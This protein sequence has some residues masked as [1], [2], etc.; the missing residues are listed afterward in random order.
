MA[1]DDLETGIGVEHARQHKPDALRRGLDIEAPAGAQQAG[2]LLRVILVIG[3]DDGGLRDRRV[4]VDR[5]IERRGPLIDRPEALVIMEDAVGQTVDHR[6]FEAEL[7]HRAVELVGR[8]MRIGGRQGRKGG[9]AV[10]M[11]AHRLMQ[12]VV[13]AAR[14]RHAGRGVDALQTGDR[15]RQHLK[16]DAAFVHFCEPQC[17]EIVEPFLETT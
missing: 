4:D 9:E 2:M 15:M 5:H 6:A 16:I 17:A 8:G 14:Q 1:E 12:P 3:V 13:D 11:G 7:R 10:G